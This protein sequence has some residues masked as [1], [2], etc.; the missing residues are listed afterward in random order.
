MPTPPRPRSPRRRAGVV[1][2]TAAVAVALVAGGALSASAAGEGTGR[3]SLQGLAARSGLRIGTAV[4]TDQ[5]GAN[6]R[7]D[8]IT[9][10]QFGSVTPENV[11]TYAA[12]MRTA[13]TLRVAPATWQELFFPEAHPGGGS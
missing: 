3:A 12:F 10:Q 2:V 8:A 6:A 7:Y 11:M 1:A 5:L 4:N 13:G 9:A